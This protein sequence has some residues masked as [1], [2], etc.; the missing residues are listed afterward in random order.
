MAR[1]RV[2]FVPPGVHAPAK[3]RQREL[4]EVASAMSQIAAEAANLPAPYFAEFAGVLAQA[5]AELRRDLTHWLKN[6]K[7]GELRFTAQA[8]RNA[9]VQLEHTMQVLGKRVPKALLATLRAAAEGAGEMAIG[10]LVKELARF[11]AVFGET[12]RPIQLKQAAIMAAGRETLIPRFRSSAARYGADITADIR[13]QLA[14]G[15]VRGE[16]FH[17]LT[18]RLVQLGGPKGWVSL[19]GVAGE[20]G[21]YVEFISEGLFRKYRGWAER[22]VVTESLNAYN[23]HHLEGLKQAEEE[24]PGYLARWDATIDVRGCP[25]CASLD[26]KTVAIGAPFGRRESGP[27]THPPA[28]PRC[29]CALTPWR[30]EWDEARAE[31]DDAAREDIAKQEQEKIEEEKRALAEARERKRQE[32]QAAKAKE[33][34]QAAARA[35]AEA[36]ARA[37]AE[38]EARAARAAAE[39]KRKAQ[40]A[41]RAAK[42][43]A[44][45]LPK[46]ASVKPARPGAARAG[47]V[48]KAIASLD[49]TNGR[50][51][52]AKAVRREFDQIMAGRG[53]HNS[54]AAARFP[55]EIETGNLGPSVFANHQVGSGRI[56]IRKDVAARAA[57]FY[58][59][60]ADGTLLAPG[61]AAYFT[62]RIHA[63]EAIAHEVIHG[64]GPQINIFN[65]VGGGLRVEEVATEVL[66]R[67]ITREHFGVPDLPSLQAGEW[68]GYARQINHMLDDIVAVTKDQRD[69]ALA[70]RAAV[71][72]LESAAQSFKSRSDKHTTPEQHV[73]AFVADLG[74]TGAEATDMAA[75]IHRRG[76]P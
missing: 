63:V 55:A 42:A 29:R 39:A 50:T 69:I 48:A 38:A 73:D 58:E 66:A 11:G 56:R 26:G 5:Q 45:K 12:I 76:W 19:R 7:D 25:I 75:R 23:V 33:E 52:A 35:K 36:A 13:R 62:D 3:P 46:P 74:L 10:H 68:G 20:P 61:N 43:A 51:P 53:L 47:E 59:H 27:Y 49:D 8:Y 34:Q 65:T 37:K 67:K 9:L 18:N 28:H 1:P 4:R 44:A 64:H 30:K 32:A 72:R 21:S 22:V 60:L 40:A 16:T 2:E 71:Q 14:V 70:R 6:V 17:E 54:D 41:A 15:I 31:T 57:E 24:D